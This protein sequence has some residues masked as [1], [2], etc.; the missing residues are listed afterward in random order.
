[1]RVLRRALRCSGGVGLPSLST[2]EREVRM[3]A[4][5]HR[6]V[7]RREMAHSIKPIE[8]LEDRRMLSLTY[9]VS[10]TNVSTGASPGY[11]VSSAITKLNDL[12][13]ESIRYWFDTTFSTS[14]Q[15]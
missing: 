11:S 13:V 4:T 6:A 7:R 3:S 10:V 14:D 12:G 15:P 1:M 8:P 9:G 5:A 2:Q